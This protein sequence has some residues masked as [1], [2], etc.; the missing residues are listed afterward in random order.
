MMSELVAGPAWTKPPVE[1]PADG[2]IGA[3]AAP[4]AVAVP[5]V[6]AGFAPSVA[7]GE[8]DRPVVVSVPPP[9][10]P[11][12]PPAAP[13]AARRTVA[14][15]VASAFLRWTTQMLPVVAEPCGGRSSLAISARML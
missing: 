3:A 11:P 8:D 15:L 10:P 7:V 1:G 14:S 13:K 12:P 4:E 6:P 9:P 5:A 2:V